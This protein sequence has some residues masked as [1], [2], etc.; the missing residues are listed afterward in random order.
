MNDVSKYLK[1]RNVTDSCCILQYADSLQNKTIIVKGIEFEVVFIFSEQ[2][3]PILGIKEANERLGTDIGNV[4]TIGLL[5][6]DD[7]I[8]MD[9]K[10]GEI[11][12]W[13]IENGD[14][15]RLKVA[16]SFEKFIKL[17]ES[18]H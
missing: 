11:F 16:D 14:G 6:G 7:P 15:A 13:L 1:S 18:S 8:C 4:V 10:T 5:A 3:K 17:A 12:F 9:T 2:T